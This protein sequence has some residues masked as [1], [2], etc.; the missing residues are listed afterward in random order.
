MVN[1]G[2]TGTRDG[3]NDAQ[4]NIVHQF[5]KLLIESGET[6]IALHHGDCVGVD[7]E[8]ANIA[9][10]LGIKTIC[11]PPIKSDLR[12]FHDSDVVMERKPYFER[13][14]DIVEACEL[15]LIHI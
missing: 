11:Y 2:V 3:M 1:V 5:F 6:E 14:R 12:A 7:F 9:Q 10:C 15:S 13:N 8:C 4:R